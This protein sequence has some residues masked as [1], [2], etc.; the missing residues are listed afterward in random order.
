MD[1]EI[2]ALKIDDGVPL[3]SLPRGARAQAVRLVRQ[4]GV[5][6]SVFLPGASLNDASSIVASARS[7]SVATLTCRKVEG[8]YRIWRTQ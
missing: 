3:S 5:G 1:E 7:G 4:I 2:P 8:G 6:Q